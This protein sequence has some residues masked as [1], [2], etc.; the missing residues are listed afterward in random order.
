MPMINLLAWREARRK[1]REKRFQASAL[2]A[3]VLGVVIV[4]FTSS[5]IDDEYFAQQARNQYLEKEI[6]TLEQIAKAKKTLEAKKK[7]LLERMSVIE[8]LQHSR[9][10]TVRLFN[11]V[12]AILPD[13]IFLSSVS[14]NQEEMK[15]SGQAGSNSDVSEYMR[16]LSASEHVSD[17]KLLSIKTD[18]LEH[19]VSFE[20]SVTIRKVG[21]LDANTKKK[22]K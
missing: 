13:G 2:A 17:P 12:P 15:I 10:R 5:G 16:R 18:E 3:V 8:Q 9:T 11:Q 20:M 7:D 22:K 1:E 21:L 19:T 4:Y 14:Q 6:K